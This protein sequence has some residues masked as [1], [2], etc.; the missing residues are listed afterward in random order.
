[1]K[2]NAR[3]LFFT[4]AMVFALPRPS[5]AV[6]WPQFRG[7][8][9]DGVSQATA[10]PLHWSAKEHVDWKQAIP[11]GGWSSPVLS[12]GKLYLTTAVPDANGGISL[13]AMCLNA[14]D[15]RPNWD[16]EV[17][18]PESS[19]AQQMHSKNSLAS[20][21]CLIDGDRLYV[22]FGHMGTAALDLAGKV[23][24]KQTTLKYKPRHGAAGSPVLVDGLLVFNCDAEENPFLA[25]LDRDSGDVRWKTDRRTSAV[26]K[27][28][29]STPT[30]IEVDG[31]KQIISAGSGF[32]GAYNPKDGAEIWKVRY[33]EGYS[34]VPRPVF[35]H[36]LVFVA[37][38]FE[39]A[40]LLAID[41]KDAKG[42]VT[43]SHVK[44]QHDRG[45][46][47]TSS[48]VVVG[49]EVYFVS[50]N[51]V[52]SCLDA[53]TGKVHWTERLG[54]DFSASPVF[55]AGRVYFQSEEG[56]THVV[57]ADTTFQELATNEIEERTLAS[58]AVSDDALFLRS[59]SHLWR[60]GQ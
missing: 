52:A 51:G 57:A 56:T 12:R 58:A 40:I 26:K 4:A 24:W 54:G 17:F 20:P 27:F 37:S 2:A 44:W 18:R 47:L 60:I 15:G 50:D 49:D 7:P 31:A 43:E 42:D 11:G 28:S 48:V 41:P 23:V 22:H 10:A 6:D 30:I 13:R 21:T 5:I 59:E 1:L 55:A 33:G 53:M 3:F 46:P 9:G 14:A 29:F 36:G 16:V 39:K 35:A 34:V 38:G 19:A 45:A 25:A 32:V 8:N